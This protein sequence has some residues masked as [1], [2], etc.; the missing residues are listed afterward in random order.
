MEGSANADDEV[1]GLCDGFA[2][3]G[4]DTLRQGLA[5]ANSPEDSSVGRNIEHSAVDADGQLAGLDFTTGES[6]DQ[7]LFCT[8]GVAGGQDRQLNAGVIGNDGLYLLD[9]CSYGST[10]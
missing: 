9:S 7:L 4:D 6:L 1:L 2:R 5:P 10:R 3:D 8:L